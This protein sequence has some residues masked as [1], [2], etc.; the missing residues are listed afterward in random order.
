M[1]KNDFSPFYVAWGHLMKTWRLRDWR[2]PSR[3]KIWNTSNGGRSK[4]SR[5]QAALHSIVELF[6]IGSS[7]AEAKRRRFDIKQIICLGGGPFDADAFSD[8]LQERGL[9]IV[10][11]E[12]AS[13]VVVLGREGWD[14]DEIDD[15]IDRH[16]GRSLRIYSQEML[17]A[18]LANGEDPFFGGE[19]VLAA[20]KAGH[21]GLEFL[22]EG[23][24]GW[25]QAWVTED[26]SP[27][28]ASTFD[29]E[30]HQEE[31]PI[32]LM[33]YKVGNNGI[34]PE[35][36]QDILSRAFHGHLPIVGPPGYMQK[37]GEPGSPTRLR[38]IAENI[39]SYC[40]NAR[41]RSS[42][43]EQA[44]ADWEVDLQWLKE[45]FYHGHMRFHWPDTTV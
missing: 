23:W 32:H 21:P 29:G 1:N 35:A 38:Q 36:R 27:T 44:I 7:K 12:S 16:V 25:V 20:F 18:A 13:G 31:S 42:S 34:D 24:P 43:M 45:T 8:F 39:A 19:F 17:V 40:R 41:R 5:P 26:R 15:V 4:I 33:G 3:L 11:K 10:E 28:S 14:E 6:A 37:W 2:T 9:Q 30:F 22:S